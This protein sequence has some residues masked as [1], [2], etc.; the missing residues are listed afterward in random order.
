MLGE[1]WVLHFQNKTQEVKLSTHDGCYVR[2][3]VVY[4][5]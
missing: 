2:Y 3:E 5:F 1:S 4:L